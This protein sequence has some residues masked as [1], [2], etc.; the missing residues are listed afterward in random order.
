MTIEPSFMSRR[1][2]LVRS[3]ATIAAPAILA[4]A[5]HAYPAQPAVA[6]VPLSSA[7]RTVPPRLLPVPDTVSDALKPV[8]GAPLQAGWNTIPEDLEGWR[9]FAAASRDDTSPTLVE[10]QQKL[11]V[12]V[13]PETMGGVNV[14]VSTP[15]QRDHKNDRRMLMHLHGGGYVLFPGLVGAGEGMMMAG[16]SGFTVVS[17]D[18]RMAPDFLFPAPLDDAISVWKALL[19]KYD[20]GKMAIF[21]TSAGGGLTLATAL[22]ARDQGLALPAALGLGS[23]WVD[24]TGDGD[25][26]SANAFVDN[27]LVSNDGW[28][29]A[30]AKLYAGKNDL[31]NPLI[32]P[33]YGELTGLPPSI[34]TTGTRDLLLS[35]T[36][37]THRKL[38]KAG[39]EA[40]LQVFEAQSHAQFLTPFA[41]ETEEAFKEIAE[42]FDLRLAA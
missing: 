15:L 29:G 23:P 36:V 22:R 35:D 30:A 18:Y 7:T 12:R 9:K 16:Y 40:S 39:V 38:R 25:S 31:K 3:V 2:L 19:A 6:A 28:V 1:Q 14:F 8:V 10:I 26:L 32:S 21:G 37:R 4:S 20:A 34:L 5:T 13:Q 11:G 41:P 42:F 27:A 33:I 24:L 17:V